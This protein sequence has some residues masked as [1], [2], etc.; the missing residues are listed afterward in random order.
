MLP[1]KLLVQ[2]KLALITGASQGLGL[3]LAEKLYKKG[4]SVILVARRE[5]VIQKEAERIK[6]THGKFSNTV[7]F[8]ACD[9]SDYQQCQQMW[10]KLAEDGKDPDFIFNC[11]GGSVC[12][13]F[14]DLT[15]DELSLGIN[16]NYAATL[17]PIHAGIKQVFADN[18]NKHRKEFKHRHII[19]FLSVAG[20]Y[21]LIGYS[22]YAPLKMALTALS[23]NLRQELTPY[24]YR[25]SCIFP[26]NF[27]SEGYQEEERTKPSITKKIEGPSAAISTSKAADIILRD[28]D[29]GY[30]VSYTDTI[31]W[32]LSSASLGTNPRYWSVLQIIV[33]F[34]FSI[35][36]P[37]AS[38]VVDRDIEGY[39]KEKD[40]KD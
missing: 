17:F 20:V 32:I 1:G 21:P 19:I 8:I 25:V 30:D 31:G 13:L 23:L 11:V 39:F 38:M 10:E 6:S 29:H 18:Q 16:T 33:N 2:D 36:A 26:G 34:L 35:I 27:D 5:A 14:S 3:E 7:D 28:L 40:K 9:V 4:C 22:Q 37:L 15:G 12:K 24:N